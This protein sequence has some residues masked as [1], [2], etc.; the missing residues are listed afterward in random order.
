MTLCARDGNAPLLSVVYTGVND[1]WWRWRPGSARRAEP[2]R[3]KLVPVRLR[4]GMVGVVAVGVGA[5]G[6][7]CGGSP[8]PSPS[9]SRV[10]ITQ[11]T[12]TPTVATVGETVVVALVSAS[13]GRDGRVVPWGRPVSDAPGV[14]APTGTGGPAGVACPRPATCTAFTARTVGVATVT[15]VGPSG[16]LC[17]RPGGHC[18]AVAAVRRR[19]VVRVVAVS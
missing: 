6:A 3:W 2:V 11:S 18:M 8:S 5:V 12:T 4:R 19:F 13:Y 15:A 16:I 9:P 7:A 10:V 1:V 14:L 17:T